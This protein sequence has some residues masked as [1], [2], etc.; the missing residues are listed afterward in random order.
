MLASQEEKNGQNPALH[1]GAQ[2]RTDLIGLLPWLRLGHVLIQDSVFPLYQEKDRGRYVQAPM[3]EIQI[4]IRPKQW[5]EKAEEMY[6]DENITFDALQ[7]PELHANFRQSYHLDKSNTPMTNAETIKKNAATA[8]AEILCV[9]DK[10]ERSGNGC[11]QR[12]EDDSE[13]GSIRRDGDQL[14]YCGLRQ[15]QF[16]MNRNF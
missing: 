14:H 12:A 16:L 11:G 3:V 15:E 2:P 1:Q 9:I 8:R 13:Y 4:Y 7:I 10:W 6:N 5:F